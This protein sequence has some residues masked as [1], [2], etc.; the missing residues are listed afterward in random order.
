MEEA[1]IRIEIGNRIKH[2]REKQ[3]LTQ[4]ELANLTDMKRP[5]IIRLEKGKCST[6]LE[7]LFRITQALDCSIEIIENKH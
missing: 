5:N 2:L 6:G 1:N 7:V 4:E 3:G